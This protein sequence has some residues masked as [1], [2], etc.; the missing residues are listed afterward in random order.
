[1]KLHLSLP[2]RYVPTGCFGRES[3]EIK[4][5]RQAVKV[6]RLG[7]HRLRSNEVR[8]W[9]SVLEYDL[10][11]LWRQQLDPGGRVVKHAR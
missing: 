7:C 3:P 1:M 2:P 9:L 11:N 4:E 10:G 5:G 6:T 8:L